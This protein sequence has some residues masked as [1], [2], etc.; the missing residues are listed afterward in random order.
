M[1]RRIKYL[2]SALLAMSLFLGNMVNVFAATSSGTRQL[3]FVA[4]GYTEEGLHYKI[5]EITQQNME[6]DI[7]P[8]IVVS[9]NKEFFVAYEGKIVPPETF[10]YSQYES[11]YNTVMTGTLKLKS[12]SY[13]IWPFFPE[14]TKATYEGV[15]FGHI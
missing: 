2:L 13:D 9:K 10:N 11:D 7:M 6:N 14:S 3:V 4:E 1:K 8:C 12:Y 15:I 5:Y